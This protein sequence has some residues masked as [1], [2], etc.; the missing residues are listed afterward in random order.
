MLGKTCKFDLML[1]H[2]VYVYHT[3]ANNNATLCHDQFDMCSTSIQVLFKIKSLFRGKR[4]T[5][6]VLFLWKVPNSNNLNILMISKK[7]Y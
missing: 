6:W 2:F 7:K 5:K 1:A 3:F 4:V